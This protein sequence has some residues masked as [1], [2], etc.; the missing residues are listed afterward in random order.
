MKKYTTAEVKPIAMKDIDALL[1]HWPGY[2]WKQTAD[3]QQDEYQR[4]I[5]NAPQ[6]DIDR[7]ISALV[8][9]LNSDDIRYSKDRKTNIE[10]ARGSL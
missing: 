1:V 2:D 6:E 10:T 8:D 4:A 5:D 3:E 9:A 7:A